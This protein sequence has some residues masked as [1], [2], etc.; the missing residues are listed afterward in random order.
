[1][2]SLPE[3]ITLAQDLWHTLKPEWQDDKTKEDIEESNS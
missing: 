3:F 2:H 1:M